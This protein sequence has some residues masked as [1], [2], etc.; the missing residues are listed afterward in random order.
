MAIS[1]RFYSV[2]GEITVN[3]FLP[4]MKAALR[5]RF[6]TIIVGAGLAGACAALAL[7]RRTRVLV[8]D[9]AQPAAGASG[10]AAGLVNPLM[11]QKARLVWQAD[12]ALAALHATLHEADATALFQGTGLLRPATNAAQA[13]RLHD[14]AQTLPHHAAWLPADAARERFPGLVMHTG[15]LLVRQGGAIR[16]PDYVDALLKAAQRCG[17][18]VQTGLHV[19]GWGENAEGAFVTIHDGADRLYARRVVLAIGYGYHRHPALRALNL[20]AIKGQTVRV[21]RPEALP[22]DG[23]LPLSG[24]GYVV[25]DGEAFVIGSSYER[26][27]TDLSPGEEQTRQILAKAARM[28]PALKDTAVLDATAGVRVTVPGTR[29]P[30]LGP[31]PGHARIWLFTGLSSKGLLM[32]PLMARNLPVFFDNP[33]TIP[34]EV[35]VTSR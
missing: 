25:P 9:A 1:C 18:E 6:E 24:Q 13:Q 5:E 12:A 32:A 30:M 34:P 15:A 20:H 16:V 28:L 19:D 21:T 7:S 31:L 35:R 17:A 23:L 3:G 8:L 26:G 27:F 11:G 4:Q 14:V 10:A 22:P 33:E 2:G 29:L